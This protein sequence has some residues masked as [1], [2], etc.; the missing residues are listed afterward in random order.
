LRTQQPGFSFETKQTSAVLVVFI[1]VIVI[2]NN[3]TKRIFDLALVCCQP[4]GSGTIPVV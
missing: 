3:G 1:A 4:Y 2:V